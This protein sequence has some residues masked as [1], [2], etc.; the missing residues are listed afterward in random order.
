[1]IDADRLHAIAAW[2]RDLEPEALERVR[3]SVVERRYPAGAVVCEM[4]HRFDHWMGVADGLL[5]MRTIS[6]E[7]KEVSLSGV[8]SGGWFGEGTVL[9]NEMR[10]YDIVAIRASNLAMI[11]RSTFMWLFEN[12]GAFARFLVVQMNERLGHFIG[13]LENDRMLD[14]TGRVARA[15]AFMINP[16]LY[17]DS[18]RHLDLTQEELGLLAGVS[19][20]TANQAIRTLQEQGLIRSEYGGITIIDLDRLK[21]Y[22]AE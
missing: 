5:K 18:G 12:S 10:R 15:V 11:D 22:G 21:T 7:G 3:S 1:M 17:P 13:L 20:P 19:R 6:R 2:S 16:V 14:A 9:K 8:H 4:G